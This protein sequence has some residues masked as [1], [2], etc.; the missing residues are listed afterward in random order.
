MMNTQV[1]KTITHYTETYQKL[2]KR[3]P[4][5][6]ETLENGWLIVNQARMSVSELESLTLQLQREMFKETNQPPS[7]LLK[8]LKWLKQ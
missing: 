5:Q 4:R 6:I 3:E 8:L 2:Y 1:E 7:P